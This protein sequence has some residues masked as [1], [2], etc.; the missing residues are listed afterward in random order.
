M[1]FSKNDYLK[2]VFILV[3]ILLVVDNIKY[4]YRDWNSEK[5]KPC[6]KK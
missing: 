6:E 4:A 2:L 3:F 1:K 5:N